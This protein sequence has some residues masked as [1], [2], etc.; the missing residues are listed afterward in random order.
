MIQFHDIIGQ[1]IAITVLKKAMGTDRVSHAYLFSGPE[2]VGK[3]TTALVFAAAL[4][5]TGEDRSDLEP[6]G[7]CPSC[8]LMAA[9]N[10]PDVTVISPDG[11]QTKIDQMREL[12]RQSQFAPTRGKWKVN[13]IERAESLNEDSASAILKTLEEPQ[14]YVVNILITRNP[15]VILPTIRSRCQLIRFFPAPVEELVPKLME[16]LVVTEDQARLVAAYSEGR[17]GKAISLINDSSFK[18]IREEMISI[19]DRLSD[20]DQA[21]FLR[22]SERFRNITSVT[23][24]KQSD[25]DEEEADDS[26][27]PTAPK[28]K[29]RVAVGRALETAV[30]WYRDLLSVRLRGEDAPLINADRREQV[31]EQ[32]Y[33]YAEPSQLVSALET[34]NWARRAIERNGNI[35]LISDVTMLRLALD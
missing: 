11:T 32:A 18:S 30:L 17:T 9:G 26:S 7:K 10:H 23:G 29:T 6:C 15:G 25:E 33:R 1:D 21:S 35:Q 4:N 31:I 28:A 27:S 24:K 22:L 12:R 34:L 2:G 16:R 8:I 3:A 14:P 5:C 20:G 19:A 13:I